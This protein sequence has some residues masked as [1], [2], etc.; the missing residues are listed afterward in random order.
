MSTQK[1]STPLL[2]HQ[3]RLDSDS[4]L[5]S[6]ASARSSYSTMTEPYDRNSP[7]SGLS[8]KIT[9][10]T[11]DEDCSP[12]SIII[13]FPGDKNKNIY[14]SAQ[15]M[16]SDDGATRVL[17]FADDPSYHL[18]DEDQ[19]KNGRLVPVTSG[20]ST[21]KGN[22]SSSS[23]AAAREKELEE[24]PAMKSAIFCVIPLFMGYACLFSLQGKI[25]DAYGITTHGEK[26][27]Q[28][29]NAVSFLYMGNLVFR[30]AHNI[31]FFCFSPRIRVL[32]AMLC[33]VASLNLLLW[34]V[35]VCK[36]TQTLAWEYG[37]YALGGVAVGSF[38]ANLL[39]AITPLGH[40]T[41]MW[42]TLGIPIGVSAITIGAFGAMAGGLPVEYIY[43]FVSICLLGSIVVFIFILP[44]KH[45]PGNADS[46][47]AFL[48]NL[49]QYDQWFWKIKWHCV[50]L[51][52][53]MLVVS[54]FS[55]GVML[56]I[57]SN[58]TGVKMFGHKSSFLMSHDAFFCLYNVFTFIGATAS[59]KYAYVDKVDR[60]IGLFLLF[61]AAGVAFNVVASQ[62][63]IG[64]LALFGGMCVFLG[65]GSIYNR[66][67][68]AVDNH[69]GSIF[70]LTALSA[71]LLVGD[72]G[73][74]LGSNLTPYIA[75]FLGS[76]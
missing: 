59:R 11:N 14:G 62:T 56:Y 31:L 43:I 20:D 28:F 48:G 47:S 61:S 7:R 71:W 57:F 55:P 37:A 16:E 44:Y 9:N 52:M 68:K 51:A 58:K 64:I 70:N 15:D 25:K 18:R 74:V 69:V 49:K 19:R 50:C 29:G 6:P 42:A 22:S 63:N 1:M 46:M 67:T 38:E 27:D 4:R 66:T 12:D 54:T 26:F 60:P 35:F 40:Q 41:K 24:L 30:F 72:L 32:I 3:K 53:N 2:R 75:Q 34:G 76:H 8:P 5:D 73:S 21:R 39:S 36:L 65:N 13:A 23:V 45:I 17:N 33:M 10:P